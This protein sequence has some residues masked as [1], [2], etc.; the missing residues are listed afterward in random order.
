[1]KS[2]FISLILLFSMLLSQD[3]YN[4]ET[5]ETSISQ[6]VPVFYQKYFHCVDIK[7]SESGNYINFYYNG[8]AP[9]DS[10]Y[11]SDS[12]PN[13]I[14]WQAQNEDSFLIPN[15]YIAEM[16]YVISIP[17]DPIPRNSEDSD[18]TICG[19][20]EGCP[21]EVDGEVTSSGVTYEYPMGSV[22]SALNGVNIFNP[23]AAPPDVIE[24]E[25]AS[26]DLY[27]GH[28]AGSSGIYHY[29]TTSAGPLEVL[30]YKMPDIMMNTTPGSGEIELYGI[31][32]DGTVILGCTEL[33]GSIV[34]SSDWDAQNGHVHDLI[35]ETG[36][37]LLENRY[38]T[39]I[40][41]TEVTDD[42]TDGNGFQEHE[43][44]PEI[45]Y[46]KTSGM[47]QSFDR[48][49]AMSAPIEPDMNTD[50][51]NEYIDAI[52]GKL[53]IESVYPN[54]FNPGTTI[55]F[56]VGA[57]SKVKLEVYSISG[58]Y[59]KTLYEG[60]SNIG[61]YSVFWNAEE[62]NSGIYILKLSTGDEVKTQKIVLA[63]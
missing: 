17:V 36:A 19:E 33:D 53:V 55:S 1:M 50:L 29:H 20:G 54:P 48:C 35:D 49:A 11:Y 51:S 3:L 61:N 28:P 46:Y 15:A 52:P 47:G 63:K 30:Q 18:F 43:F 23:C 2:V 14:P 39:H 13:Y 26:F 59:I 4:L 58:R 57:L 38:H 16:D 8:L 22:G 21:D 10:W 24:D 62:F 31:M 7:L 45:S 42:D 60:Y 12:N 34:D 37:V 6:D 27:S 41:Y 40:C 5:C 25:A 44:T 32:C 56:F 9:Y